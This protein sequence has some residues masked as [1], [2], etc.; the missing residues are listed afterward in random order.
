M[1]AMFS[2][3]MDNPRGPGFFQAKSEKIKFLVLW[4]NNRMAKFGVTRNILRSKKVRGKNLF[5]IISP[6]HIILNLKNRAKES[7][8]NEL[9]DILEIHGSLIDRTVA[10]KDLLEREQAMSTAIPNGIAIT[11]AKPQPSTN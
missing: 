4:C 5:S 1:L 3:I 9:F 7:I 6:T 8:I 2:A 10:L 11:H